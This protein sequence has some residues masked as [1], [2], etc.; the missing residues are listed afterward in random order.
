VVEQ[1]TGSDCI[2]LLSY[3]DGILALLYEAHGDLDESWLVAIDR[4]IDPHEDPVKLVCP[5]D[6]SGKLFVRQNGSYLYYGTHTGMSTEHRHHEWVIMGTNLE[7]GEKMPVVQLGGFVG[8]DIGV[9]VCFEIYNDY[10]YALSNQT[11]FDVEEIDWTSCYHCV[12]FPVS[13][14]S[15]IRRYD[16]IWRRQHMEGPINDT[17]TYLSLHL[18]QG[19]N[20]VVIVECR[21]EWKD[22]GSTSMRTFYNMPLPFPN[23]SPISNKGDDDDSDSSAKYFLA[24]DHS[25]PEHDILVT[26]IDETNNPIYV[27]GRT[28]LPRQCHPEYSNTDSPP[29]EFILAKTKY[30]TYNL[31]CSAFLDLV[32]DPP[33]SPFSAS[34][35]RLRLRIGHRKLKS[36]L[37]PDEKGR[38]VLRKPK[39]DPSGVPI[40]GSEE[41]FEDRGVEMWP[42]EDAP[43]EL[44]EV[45]CPFRSIGK[46]VAASDERSVIY[47]TGP[48]YSKQRAIVLINF[49]P[50][51]SRVLLKPDPAVNFTGLKRLLAPTHVS[52][53]APSL[54]KGNG[55]VK[56]D[57]ERLGAGKIRDKPRAIPID[58]APA[59]GTPASSAAAVSYF[60]E[61]NARYLSINKGFWLR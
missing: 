3:K 30:R 38:E 60:C 41:E 11:S 9:T 22:G 27:P 17:W 25:F 50:T 13:N 28:H 43:Q 57:V 47:M 32:N 46:V 10:F 56:V 40:P 23:E 2:T 39:E 45:L 53:E 4:R 61:G 14:P 24:T 20:H 44:L 31:A 33:N 15:E 55:V 6:H 18:D 49:D 35:G 16:K 52:G 8:S 51:V 59:T 58:P 36:P 5:I 26:Q 19:N 34:R 1:A 48:S 42:P 37:S 54:G 21:R 29:R 12:R 7:A